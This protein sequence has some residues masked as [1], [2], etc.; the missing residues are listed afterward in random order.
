[1]I[2]HA[3]PAWPTGLPWTTKAAYDA[4]ARLMLRRR[5]EAD[6]IFHP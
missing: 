5:P 1:M 6:E 3:D 4:L 2:D